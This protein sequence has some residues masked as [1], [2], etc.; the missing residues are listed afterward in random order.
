VQ[1]LALRLIAHA[2]EGS[3]S[4]GIHRIDLSAAMPA[5]DDTHIHLFNGIVHASLILSWYQICV[6]TFQPTASC[7]ITDRTS[8]LAS[9]PLDSIHLQLSMLYMHLL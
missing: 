4:I 6:R 1:L 5:Q 7:L 3:D 2:I 8:I 9:F